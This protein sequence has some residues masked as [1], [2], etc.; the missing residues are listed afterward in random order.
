LLI[1]DIMTDAVIAIGPDMPIVDAASMMQLR[2]IQHFPVMDKEGQLVGIVSDRDILIIGSEH[3]DAPAGLSIKDPIKK[4]MTTNIKT[5]QPDNPIEEVAKR[6]LELN[7]GSMPVVKNS[8]LVGIVTAKDFLKSVEKI[9][10]GAEETIRLEIEVDN[11]PGALAELLV[12][13]A[14]RSVNVL[15]VMT[16]FIDNDLVCFVLRVVC[17][18]PQELIEALREA[19]F[20][21]TWPNNSLAHSA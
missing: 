14:K 3:A 21:V 10:G 7:I 19:D 11:R 15:G 6:M 16:S 5:C 20:H 18:Q 2:K 1:K 4:V 13:L 12:F 9:M 17:K 8:K